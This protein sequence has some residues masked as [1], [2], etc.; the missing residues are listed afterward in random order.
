MKKGWEAM[1]RKV[2]DG[3]VKIGR[4]RGEE[5]EKILVLLVE[6]ETC[7]LIYS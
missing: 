2:G 5:E 6:K 3:K 1:T 4:G 7:S